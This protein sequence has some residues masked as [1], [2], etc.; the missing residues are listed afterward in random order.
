MKL[1]RG[2]LYPAKAA[3]GIATMHAIIRVS[4]HRFVFALASM[5]SGMKKSILHQPYIAN[6]VVVTENATHCRCKK[7]NAGA[8]G[9]LG[10]TSNRH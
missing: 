7:T 9:D 6:L 8:H 4:T 2:K 1:R 10:S 5:T 3:C